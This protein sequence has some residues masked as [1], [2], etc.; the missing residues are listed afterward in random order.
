MHYDSNISTE[1]L[2][3]KNPAIKDLSYFEVSNKF[4]FNLNDYNKIG[5]Y[6]MAGALST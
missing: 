4:K 2:K 6:M 3:R 5:S 1:K